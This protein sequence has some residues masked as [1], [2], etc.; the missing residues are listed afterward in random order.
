M[1]RK[2]LAVTLAMSLMFTIVISPNANASITNSE[3]EDCGDLPESTGDKEKQNEAKS[4][5]MKSDMFKS[6]KRELDYSNR[7]QYKDIRVF[8]TENEKIGAVLV[9]ITGKNSGHI[10]QYIVNLET[11]EIQE[12][13]ITFSK[14]SHDTL[15]MSFIINGEKQKDFEIN[16]TGNIITNTGETVSVEEYMELHSSELSNNAPIKIN[17]LCEDLASSFYYYINAF[18]CA[19]A[20]LI[21][22]V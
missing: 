6:M 22:A 5:L 9:P 13:G 14:T 15:Q 19:Y 10:M 2:I 18:S 3:C 12:H 17:G 21:V 16:K 20:C 7:I 8:I 4:I 1:I 11:K